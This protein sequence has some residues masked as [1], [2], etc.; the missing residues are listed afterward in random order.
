MSARPSK[1]SPEIVT[2]LSQVLWPD[3]GG[4]DVELGR[5]RSGADRW[6]LL[7]DDRRPT[8]LVP[9]SRREGAAALRQFN[10]GMTQVAR[11]RKAAIST[12]LRCG[13]ARFARGDRLLVSAP[14]DDRWEDLAGSVLPKILGVPRVSIAISVG[15]QLRPNLKPVLQVT[16]REGGVLAY[17][18]VGWNDLTKEL[19]VRE[20]EALERYR[21]G[22]PRTFALPSL[23][24]HGS[25]NGVELTVVSP[26]PQHVWRVGRYDSPPDA[27]V[28]G[29]I[30]ELGGGIGSAA[31]GE[32]AY[33]RGLCERVGAIDEGA[34]DGRSLASV[35]EHISA[36]HGDRILAFGG[37]HGDFTPWNMTATRSRPFIWDWER[38]SHPAPLGIDAVHLGFEVGVLK[39]GLSVS[40]ASRRSVQRADAALRALG[41][42][43]EQI[44]VV[45]AL[46]LIERA[47][48]MEEGRRAGVS[49]D[50]GI[51]G[52]LRHELLE[53]RS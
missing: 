23:L 22:G 30:A 9:G 34:A 37:S 16:S 17:A 47:V 53:V 40:A 45:R 48:R 7:P 29:E 19:V 20:A 13:G 49:I 36:R 27:G 10:D 26:G 5:A 8:L 6:L 25:W 32:S 14:R 28:V 21:A 24:H 11:L 15:R 41:L 52:G 42:G 50:E 33:W 31:L 18:K 4:Y 46:Q 3:A 39:R 12:F 44:E 43:P 35:T 1:G 2:W 51:A 38:W